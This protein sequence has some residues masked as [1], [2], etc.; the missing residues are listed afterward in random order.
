MASISLQK[1]I[2]AEVYPDGVDIEQSVGYHRVCALSFDRFRN[3]SVR[4]GLVTVPKIFCVETGD[5]DRLLGPRPGRA[6]IL[7]HEQRR[8]P[9]LP[10]DHDSKLG[11]SFQP[12]RLVV[13][14][15][16]WQAGLAA[17]DRGRVVRAV[18]AVAVDGAAAQPRRLAEAPTERV[19][20]DGRGLHGSG[21]GHNDKLS[22]ALRYGD[23]PLLVDSGIAVYN[24]AFEWARTYVR[25]TKAHS[26]TLLGVRFGQHAAF[27]HMAGEASAVD[28]SSSSSNSYAEKPMPST[29][30][31]L[32]KESDFVRASVRLDTG[33]DAH[34]GASSCTAN[35]TRALHYVRGKSLWLVVD[36]MNFDRDP[37]RCDWSAKGAFLWSSWHV[38]PNATVNA[39]C[40]TAATLATQQRC[41][42]SI[43][44][45]SGNA[46]LAIAMDTDVKHAIFNF[47]VAKGID[48][49]QPDVTGPPQGWILRVTAQSSPR[50]C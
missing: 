29:N 34:F 49:S 48:D 50:R 33:S 4:T 46:S 24:G 40:A 44:H 39:T 32:S 11:C 43:V 41:L 6:R 23:F 25:S 30:Y 14:C 31:D 1:Q 42:A 26:T 20:V 27:E 47:S 5:D 45:Y 13:Y 9:R 19:A 10:E 36:R 35:H 3:E 21:H 8:Q 22:I 18:D 17:R 37:A 28:P 7:A 2:D 12:Q 16:R 38:H 15:H